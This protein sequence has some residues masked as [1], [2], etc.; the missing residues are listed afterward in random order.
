MSDYYDRKGNPMEMLEWAK[1]LETERRVDATTLPDGKWVSTVWVGLNHQFGD[2]PPLIFE[3][4]VFPS[5][6][7][8]HDLDSD[9]YATEEEA[10]FGHQRMVKKWSEGES[11]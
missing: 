4:M 1:A 8:M 9:R 3:T 2:G 11:A 5:D 10:I 6:H 7:D